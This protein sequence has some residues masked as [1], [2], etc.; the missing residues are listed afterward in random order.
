MNGVNKAETRL[1]ADSE[2]H[3][4][5]EERIRKERDEAET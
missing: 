2:E 5:E 4:N 1:E 3:H